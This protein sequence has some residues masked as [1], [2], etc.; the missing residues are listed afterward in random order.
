MTEPIKCFYLDHG[1]DTQQNG[2]CCYE[3][4]PGKNSFHEMHQQLKYIEIKQAFDSGRWPEKYCSVC[5]NLEAGNNPEYK[6]KRQWGEHLYEQNKPV[7]NKIS[8]LIVHTGTLCNLQCRSCSLYCSSSWKDENS[9]LPTIIQ[10]AE[11]PGTNSGFYV[12]TITDF[13]QEDFS[14]LKQVNLLGGEPLYGRQSFNILEKVYNEAGEN[15]VIHFTT[16]GTFAIDPAAFPWLHKFKSVNIN[17]SIDA[18]GAEAE[19]IRTGCQWDKVDKNVRN[20]LSSGIITGQVKCSP[21]YSIMNIFSVSKLHNWINEISILKNTYVN[22]VTDPSYLSYSVLTDQ[23]KELAAAKLTDSLGSFIIPRILSSTHAPD[24]RVK[25]FKFMEH[26][27]QYHN[28]DWK[29]YLP[30]LYTLM[31]H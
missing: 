12:P 21:T 16:N 30:E 2:P 15:C 25:F 20:L 24:D 4:I 11:E 22:F 1:Y 10:S 27:K 23:E 13:S 9:K 8:E 14:E 26:T 17:I 3:H 7:A 19:F 5:K 28:M 29:D 31:T 18:V 6:S